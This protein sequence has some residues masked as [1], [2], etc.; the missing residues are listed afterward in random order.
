MQHRRSIPINTRS[1]LTRYLS[2]YA[3]PEIAI[4]LRINNDNNN[5][6]YTHCLVIPA[7]NESSAFIQRITDTFTLP[8]RLLLITVI[9]QPDNA[10]DT[11][12]NKNLWDELRGKLRGKLRNEL[13]GSHLSDSSINSN[14]PYLFININPHIDC[15]AIDRFTKKIPRKQGVGLARKIGGD[16]ACQLALD[17][18]LA[19]HWVHYS[20]ADT[21]LPPD[22]FDATDN[23]Q[24][25]TINNLNTQDAQNFYS[26]V[27]YPYKHTPSGNSLVDQA[28]LQYEASLYYYVNN[29]RR[30]GSPY[31]YHTLG[32]CI[33]TNIYQYSQ[34]R[35]FP[36]RSGGEDFYLLNKLSKLGAICS[37]NAPTLSIESRASQRVPFGTGPAVEKIMAA[38]TVPNKEKNNSTPLP[39]RIDYHP[40]CFIELAALLDNFTHLYGYK[41]SADEK[42][43]LH[44]TDWLSTL[45]QPLQ[46]ALNTLHIGTL[47][48]HID[49]QINSADQCMQHCRY[50]LDG[51]RTL[52]LIHL[53][54][55]TYPKTQ[56]TGSSNN[57]QPL[58]PAEKHVP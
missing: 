54:T 19:N 28:T 36:K 49:K 33:A 42:G 2:K 24:H 26:A 8:V 25:E 53:L 20:D 5:T 47:F 32:S 27:I 9:N 56:I 31:A 4:A 29:L 7:F 44:Y 14:H 17:K 37:L 50:W 13:S 16:I 23:L 51:F 48:A 1:A 43:F 12:N 21:Y 6:P 58:Y 52:K 41:K 55:E 11:S 15:L 35:G 46:E 39:K 34:A 10:E 30:A 38:L 18:K 22:Y 3:E 57:Q 40:Q 45:S